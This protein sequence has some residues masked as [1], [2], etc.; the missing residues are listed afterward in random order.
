MIDSSTSTIT[1]FH[2]SGRGKKMEA[3][4]S[5]H[6]LTNF[7]FKIEKKDGQCQLHNQDTEYIL[8]EDR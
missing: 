5:P 4:K 7:F 2:T 3:P 6:D 1:P 8:V